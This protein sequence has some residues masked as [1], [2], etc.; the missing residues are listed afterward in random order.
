MG[1]PGHAVP[2]G[3]WTLESGRVVK[4]YL[5]SAPDAPGYFDMVW[6]RA[7]AT[8]LEDAEVDAFDTIVPRALEGASRYLGIADLDIVALR[9]GLAAPVDF[10][11]QATR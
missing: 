3:I 6:H 9:I 7:P 5:R 1:A 4:L 2:L 10:V 8:P 11:T